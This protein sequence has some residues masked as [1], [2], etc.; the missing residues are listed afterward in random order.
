MGT[1]QAKKTNLWSQYARSF[2]K[3][4]SFKKCRNHGVAH[5]LEQTKSACEGFSQLSSIFSVYGQS[6][7]VLA[8][9]RYKIME[10]LDDECQTESQQAGNGPSRRYI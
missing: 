6:F 1:K 5:S 8:L 4:S 7:D 2:F 10:V 3:L 9:R